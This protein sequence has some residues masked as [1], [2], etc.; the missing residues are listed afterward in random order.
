MNK[1]GQ[2]ALISVIFSLKLV[3]AEEIVFILKEAPLHRGL[4]VYNFLVVL[5]VNDNKKDS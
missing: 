5:V 1:V 2:N 4:R 3:H